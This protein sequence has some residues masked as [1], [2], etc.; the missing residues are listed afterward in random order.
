M[1]KEFLLWSGE[2]EGKVQKDDFGEWENFCC[3]DRNEGV[4]KDPV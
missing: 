2:D 3:T 1:K 4:R